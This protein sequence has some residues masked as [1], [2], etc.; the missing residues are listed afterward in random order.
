[1]ELDNERL[2]ALDQCLAQI[3]KH[4]GK[5]AI[6]KLGDAAGNTDID[7]IPTGCLSLDIALGIGGL[8][9]GRIVEIYGPESSGKTTV[10]LHCIAQAQKAGGIAAFVD[11]EH[12]LDPVYAKKLGV[13]LDNLYVSQPDTGEQAL[14]ITDALVRSG[15]V[16]LIVIDSVAALTPKAEIEGDMGDTYV[17]LQARLMSQALRKL[18]GIINKSHTCV[19]F[20]NQ[21][22]EKVGVMFGNPETTPGGRALKFYASVRIDVRK[23]D[24]LKDSDGIMG[25][26]TKAKVVKN[27]LAPPFKTAEFDIL[28]GEGISQE[29]CIID[30]GTA[31]GVIGKNGAWFSYEGERIAQGRERMREWL[32]AN[33]DRCK[34]IE[35]KIRAAYRTV[36]EGEEE[37]AE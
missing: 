13:D 28:Y 3:E 30:L 11:A 26:K 14:D 27:K 24:A 1:M 33:P 36:K 15:A 12:A 10:A 34:E 8:P 20:I 31:C 21:L 5:G 32:R 2:K 16:D 19:I 37:P 6:M 4:Y 9:C 25:N 35:E 22:R 18:T 7:V 29:G 17:G 23:A